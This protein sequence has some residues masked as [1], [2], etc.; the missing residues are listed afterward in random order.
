MCSDG[1]QQLPLVLEQGDKALVEGARLH[2][3]TVGGIGGGCRLS[4]FG[5]FLWCW[6]VHGGGGIGRSL[7]R[8]D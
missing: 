5:A 8:S 3:G 6:G 2:W 4:P 7:G 1:L